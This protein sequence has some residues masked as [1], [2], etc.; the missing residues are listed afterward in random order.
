METI[1]TQNGVID[2]GYNSEA[3]S[4]LL[5]ADGWSYRNNSWQK[6]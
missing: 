2:N 4:N 6:Q 5:A 3:A 1:V